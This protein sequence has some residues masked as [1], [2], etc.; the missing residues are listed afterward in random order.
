MSSSSSPSTLPSLLPLLFLVY[1]HSSSSFCS[2]FVVVV[3]LFVLFWTVGW[4][5]GF[6][7]CC[8]CHRR[9]HH[10]HRHHHHYYYQFVL[11]FIIIDAYKIQMDLF[12]ESCSS[13][14]PYCVAKTLALDIARKL[15]NKIFFFLYLT[16]IYCRHHWLTPFHWPWPCLRVTRSTQSKPIGFIFSH[17]VQLTR[18]KCDVVM[19]QFKLHILRL[20][21]IYWNE[22]RNCCFADCIQENFNV[23]M[24]LDVYE[25]IWFRFGLMIDT[26]LLYILIVVLLT[27]TLTLIQGHRRARKQN[28]RC[29]LPHKVFSGSEWNVVHCWDVNGMWY[30][31]EMWME[32]GSLLR[33]EWNVVHCWDV[34]GMWYT[35]EMWMECGA[36][37]R[38][39]RNV[40]HCWDVNG[41]WCTA[42]MWT[43]CGIL[44]RC[45]WNVVH[46]WDV[47]GMWYT[48]EMCWCGESP[49]H[50]VAS[51]Q[52]SRERTLLMWFR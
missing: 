44:L 17:S 10:H 27:L 12:N 43:E 25:S 13:G 8:C 49:T 29:P 7:V 23:D 20:P 37:L 1:C 42:E 26:I 41:M 36:L 16:C 48:A 47:N 30:T 34:N 33:C 46:C 3:V 11:Y 6:F 40:V 32:C 9:H 51:I 50:F 2:T 5:V 31:A 4:L 18:M 24:H 15:F 39:E 35:A 38:C 52:C 21:L 28:F 14:R 22:G 45:E 19:K